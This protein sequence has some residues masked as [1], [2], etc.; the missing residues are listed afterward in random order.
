VL[1]HT[2]SIQWSIS[3]F[4]SFMALARFRNRCFSILYVV[5]TRVV[6]NRDPDETVYKHDRVIY[7]NKSDKLC[8]TSTCNIGKIPSKTIP[9]SEST[10][11]TKP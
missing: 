1:G 2:V 9:R 3:T 6:K 4:L 11:F 5:W 10:G 7:Y 8:G